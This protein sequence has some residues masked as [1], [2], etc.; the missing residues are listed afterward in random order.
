MRDLYGFP[1][2]SPQNLCVISLHDLVGASPDSRHFVRLLHQWVHVAGVLISPLPCDIVQLGAIE[3]QALL[4]SLAIRLSNPASYG[5][6]AKAFLHLQL[7]QEQKS[8]SLLVLL[9]KLDVVRVLV[10]LGH[11]YSWMENEV[12]PLRYALAL[13]VPALVVARA[14]EV[15]LGV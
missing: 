14:V 12:G 4:R 8:M 7:T 13:A 1:K 9:H 2:S 5:T 11:S 10:C 3:I 15:V 6:V